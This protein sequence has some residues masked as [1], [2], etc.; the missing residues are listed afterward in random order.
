MPRFPGLHNE[1]ERMRR[2]ASDI[3]HFS[4]LFISPVK[5][6]CVLNDGESNPTPE[7]QAPS[8]HT[9]LPLVYRVITPWPTLVRP[10]GIEVTGQGRL[11]Q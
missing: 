1:T 11:R 4:A 7:W 5:L 9:R 10:G 3:L 6:E 8:R 2:H